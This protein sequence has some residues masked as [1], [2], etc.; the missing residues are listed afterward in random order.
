MALKYLADKSALARLKHEAV[1]AR[2]GPIFGDLAT[3]TVADLEILYSAKTHKDLVDVLRERRSLHQL[4]TSQA[5]FDRAVD[6]LERLARRGQHRAA[7]IPDLL[8][9]AVA[10]RHSVT[11]LH[12]DRDFDLIAAVTGQDTEWVVPPG[13]VP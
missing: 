6:V 2:L 10:E 1:A 7:G 4:A 13:S 11:L 5:D 3:C 8:V 9:A 12:Y